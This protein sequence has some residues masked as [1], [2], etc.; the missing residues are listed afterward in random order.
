MENDHGNTRLPYGLCLSA[1]INLP[2]DATPKQAWQ[3]LKNKTGFTPDHF[4]K[5]IKEEQEGY[6]VAR[7][8]LTQKEWAL[9]YRKIGE[10]EAGT[11]RERK[12]KSGER[13]IIVDKKL[14]ID[15][16]KYISPK[17]KSVMEFKT[18]DALNDYLDLMETEGIFKWD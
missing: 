4:Y 15:D 6:K 10:I 13:V 7:N 2:D 5:Q 12:S 14:I 3:A 9:Y 8:K 1:E 16:G 17:V 18:I 11:T